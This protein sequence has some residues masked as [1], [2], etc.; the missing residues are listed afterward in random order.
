MRFERVP[1]FAL[2]LAGLAVGWS[3]P[4]KPPVPQYYGCADPVALALP[5]CDT[6]KSFADR[7][8]D[9]ISRLNL[10]EKIALLSP[11]VKPYCGVHTPEINRTGLSLPKYKWLTETNSAV[12]GKDSCVDTDRCPTQ[13][14]SNAL[15]AASFNRS[16]WFAKGDV[17]STDLRVLNNYGVSDIGLTGYGP[18]I[19]TV[20]DPRYGRNSEL[21]SEDPFLSGTYAAE[22][23]A[24]MQQR[25]K[26]GFLKMLAYAKHYTAYSVEASR[27]T[28]SA[29]V[30]DF[31]FGDSYLPQYEIIFTTSGRSS[32]AMCSYFAPNGVSSCGNNWLLNQKIR[33]D[34]GRPDAVAMSDCSAVGNMQKNVMQLNAS[35]AS[36][37]AINAGLDI[38]GG[39]NDDLWTEGYLAKAVEYGL[40]TEDTITKAVRRT[41]MQKMSVGMFDPPSSQ[42]WT[43]LNYTAMNSSF[44]QRVSYEA[45]LQGLVLLKNG[46][47]GDST[48]AP[49][50][51][52]PGVRLAVVG[53]M[54]FEKE[55]LLPDYAQKATVARLTIA[56]ELAAANAGGN[57]EAQIG[58]DVDSKDESKMSAALSA[59]KAAD[60]TVMV[61]GITRDQEH[62][63]I[64]RQ[65]TLLP[66]LQGEFASRVF[67]A[68]AGKPVVLVLCN[69]GI[70]SIDALVEPSAAIVEA[71]N[72]AVMGPR[73]L[74]QLMFG[75]E[76][77]WGK[78]PVTIY[79]AE[80]T[81]QINIT[82][83]SFSKGV[84]RGYRYYTGTPLFTFGEGLSYTSFQHTCRQESPAATQQG[85]HPRSYNFS[86]TVQ[87]T[88]SRDG[89]EVVMVFHS[90]GA[91]ARKGL[92][93][94]VP[95][96]SLV[97]FDR[98]SIRA[99][100]S[101]QFNFELPFMALAVTDSS[102]DKP[103]YKGERDTIFSR[104]NGQDVVL[105]LT[106]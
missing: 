42:E 88:G 100:E 74:A 30:T 68:S 13:F 62:E 21:P 35:E 99:G 75:A 12:G 20:K 50:P 92:D 56:E 23:T 82:D 81:S 96:K 4:A 63:G 6:S 39:W 69:G 53:P 8:E 67:N 105:G 95:K 93:H 46:N 97:A 83:M 25:D 104:G 94:P 47:T 51:L 29:N 16:S 40:T 54:A 76:N 49:L 59:V 45:A 90:L 66:G 85:A 77:R 3:E 17:V 87:N 101:A 28:F 84:G 58:V 11:T 71:F 103:V 78:L 37:Q 102:G 64:D 7:V 70:L 61:L 72:P 26:K 80:Y 60:I 91:E 10:T 52:K 22:Y 19:N 73:A 31:A 18:N 43:R 15:M 38:Y 5:Y 34:W 27:F 65:D 106:V 1:R 33:T 57:T 44:A 41:L 36:A 98:K 24:G 2:A 86:C 89:D 9:I 14:V 79:P 48:G 32:G 55:G